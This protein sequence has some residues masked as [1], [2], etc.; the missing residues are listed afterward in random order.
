MNN[1]PDELKYIIGTYSTYDDLNSF[2]KVFP[3]ENKLQ[4]KLLDFVY[5]N[6]INTYFEQYR[7][8]KDTQEYL[9][10][11]P[12]Y[13][14]DPQEP[15]MLRWKSKILE[16]EFTKKKLIIK[17]IK[18]NFTFELNN[19]SMVIPI[20]SDGIINFKIIGN[21]KQLTLLELMIGGQVIDM[22]DNSF[23]DECLFDLD[24]IPLP[25]YHEVKIKVISSGPIKFNFDYVE[26]ENY[27]FNR[28]EW[29][30]TQRYY[31]FQD[32]FKIKEIQCNDEMFINNKKIKGTLNL[33]FPIRVNE[34]KTTGNYCFKVYNKLVL[35]GGMSGLVY[36]Y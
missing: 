25:M 9:K 1:L 21:Q 18:E 12:D 7:I 28:Y 26:L 29:W 3:I 34:F 11:F 32:F 23:L 31:Y 20:K 2:I 17:E 14:I 10:K 19:N 8:Y 35:Q 16:N 15:N 22:Y 33:D 30:F 24:I 6:D 36:S 13:Q 4:E 5:N 27:D